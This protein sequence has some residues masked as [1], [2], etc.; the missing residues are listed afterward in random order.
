MLGGCIT[1]EPVLA[2]FAMMHPVL[3]TMLSEAAFMWDQ[4]ALSDS[5]LVAMAT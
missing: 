4:T 2:I 1:D 3:A 5:Y